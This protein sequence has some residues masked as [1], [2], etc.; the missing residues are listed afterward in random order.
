MKAFLKISIFLLLFLTAGSCSK[1]FLELD[2]KGLRFEENFY[3]NP[4]E[5]FEGL[6]AAYDLWVRSIPQD[7]LIT[8]HT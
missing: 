8:A 6:M 7:I 4:D 3:S 1:D 5:V 2:P